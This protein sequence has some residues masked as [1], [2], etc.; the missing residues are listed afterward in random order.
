MGVVGTVEGPAL[1]D[2]VDAEVSLRSGGA[3]DQRFELRHD[4]RLLPAVLS[5]GLRADGFTRFSM[6]LR[7]EVRRDPGD[8]VTLRTVESDERGL[9]EGSGGLLSP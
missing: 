5:T 3:F 8:G 6:L 7:T 1:G 9:V 2:D 4:L